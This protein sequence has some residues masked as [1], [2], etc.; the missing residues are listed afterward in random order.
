MGVVAGFVL[1]V[2]ERRRCDALACRMAGSRLTLALLIVAS[3]VVTVSI[4]LD[5]FPEATSDLLTRVM[6]GDASRT[7]HGREQVR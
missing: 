3:L 1:Y 7:G 4:A 2:L 5:R 6:S